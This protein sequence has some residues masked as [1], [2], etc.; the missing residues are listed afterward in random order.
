MRTL[1]EVPVVVGVNGSSPGLAAVR[2]AAR[3]AAARDRELRVVH[4]FQW[5]RP[6]MGAD[7]PAFAA[8]R[9]T[10]ARYVRE[11]V[12]TAGKSAPG[13]RAT[14]HLIDGVPVRVLLRLSRTA[15]L[16]VLGGDD[17]SGGRVPADSVLLQTVSRSF[18]PTLVSRGPRPPAGPLVAAVDGSP[19]SL[20]ALRH[21]A[22]EAQCR[23]VP[24]ELV[25]V[26]RDPESEVL[27]ERLIEAVLEAVPEVTPTLTRLLIGDPARALVRVSRTARM[28]VV[29]PRGSDGA[30]LLGPVAQVLLRHGACPTLFVHGTTAAGRPSVGTVRTAGAPAG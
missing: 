8:A 18:C 26:V 9:R 12:A 6:G 15:E 23:S 22:A 25:H 27:G 28:M 7:Q 1:S 19:A 21:A 30:T 16:L 20:L 17:L 4:V 13:V 14:A 11:A 2:L 24:L 29:G 5:P 10:A 3:E